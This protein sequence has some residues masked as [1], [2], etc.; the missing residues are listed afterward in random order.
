MRGILKTVSV[1]ALV[2]TFAM[3]EIGPE[4]AGASAQVNIPA[5]Q[6]VSGQDSFVG[7]D[8]VSATDVVGVQF[9]VRYD[10]SKIKVGDPMMNEA[11]PNFSIHSSVKDGIVK[12]LAFSLTGDQIILGEGAEVLIPVK[13]IGNYLGNVNLEVMDMVIAAPDATEIQSN[14][15][16]GEITVGMDIPTNYDVQQNFPNPFNPTTTINYQLPK[17][18]QIALV[19]YNMLGQEVKTLVNDNLDAGYYSVTWDGTDNSGKMIASGEYLYS[20][21]ADDFNKNMKMVFLK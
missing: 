6:I 4:I 8:V 1:V 15:Y 14:S 7:I 16:V 12:I 9:S 18:S 2:A 3:A 17:D 11:N 21:T 20:I 10:A 5:T 13:S 19:I